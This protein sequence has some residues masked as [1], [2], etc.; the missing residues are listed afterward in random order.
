MTE[1]KTITLTLTAEEI[2]AAES[3]LVAC[4]TATIEQL[5]KFK[6]AEKHGL[7][8]QALEESII[9]RYRRLDFISKML[10]ALE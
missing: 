6:R 9:L 4:Y 3:T 1:K 2:E 8:S 10:K 7:H 5:D